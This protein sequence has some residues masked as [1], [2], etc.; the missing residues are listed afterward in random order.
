MSFFEKDTGWANLCTAFEVNAG[1]SSAMVG[2]L[3]SA[4]FYKNKADRGGKKAEP[5]TM[6]QLAAVH[7][8]GSRDGRIPERSFM[9]STVNANRSAI[10]KMLEKLSA[11]V[12]DKKKTRKQALGI[13]SQFIVDKMKGRIAEGV[14]PPNAASTVAR[15]GSNHTLIDTGQLVGSIDWEIEDKK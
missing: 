4:G 1:E 10:E 14:P 13:V 8:Y 12:I 7:E 2:V 11:Q 6:A 5:I 9:R 3:R 15:K